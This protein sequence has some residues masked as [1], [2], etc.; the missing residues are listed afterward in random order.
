M[1]CSIASL[2]LAPR[3]SRL[4]T[5]YFVAAPGRKACRLAPPQARRCAVGVP[6]VSLTVVP[7]PAQP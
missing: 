5:A 2:A 7:L 4:V 6:L 1:Q 3:G